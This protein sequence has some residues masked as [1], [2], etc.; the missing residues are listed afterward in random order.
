MSAYRSI[1]LEADWAH[2]QYYGWEEVAASSKVRLLRKRI[3]PLSRELVLSEGTAREIRAL[4]SKSRRWLHE[5]VIHD[6]CGTLSIAALPGKFRPLPRSRWMLNSATFVI[7][8]TPN[9]AAIYKKMNANTKRRI[10]KAE[11]SGVKVS[12]EQRPCNDRLNRFFAALKRM[13]RERGLHSL[14]STALARM[15]DDGRAILL[16]NDVGDAPGAYLMLYRSSQ[17]AIWLHSVGKGE[18]PDV[19]R[20]LQW[21]A[22]KALRAAGVRWYD[23]GGAPDD[24]GSGIY[25]FKEGFGGQFVTL[26]GELV[27][28]SPALD[29]ARAAV[30]AIQG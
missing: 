13:H 5:T 25:R 10:R 4:L 27:S 23:L 7:D 16:S 12:I 28:T 14:S 18:N 9:P 19:G 6:F 17:K 24:S 15:F 22:I 11:E 1:F 20:L 2:T 30:V 26:G 29:A 21:H 8:L 3:G